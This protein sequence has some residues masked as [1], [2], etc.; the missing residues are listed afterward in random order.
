MDSV[1][2]PY[3]AS[4]MPRRLA[5][6]SDA[7]NG[8]CHRSE[9]LFLKLGKD[10]ETIYNGVVNITSQTQ[11][12]ARLIR[13]ESDESV[14]RKV[15]SIAKISVDELEVCHTEAEKNLNHVKA[16]SEQ[17]G[18]LCNLC[19]TAEKVAM[20]LK[21]V[22]V[23]MGI[24]CA[25]T[26]KSRETFSGFAVEV[27]NVSEKIRQIAENIRKK[28][29]HARED[30]L[31][32]YKEVSDAMEQLRSLSGST[33]VALE[34]AVVQIEEVM[35]FSSEILEQAEVNSREIS[36]MV[37]EIVM[38]I[39][40]HDSMNQRVSHIVHAI[41][42]THILWVEKDEKKS[43]KEGETERLSYSYAILS[44]QAAQLKR[45]ISEIHEVYDKNNLAFGQI[46]LKV[47]ELAQSLK[48]LD[49]QNLKNRD[50]KAGLNPHS[51]DQPK[52]AG[53]KDPMGTL[54]TAMGDL[55]TIL[56]QGKNLSSQIRET[57][58]EASEA[59]TKLSE[60]ADRVRNIG[61]ETRL[62]AINAIVNAT[63]LGESGRTFEVIA[64]E[65][66]NLAVQSNDFVVDVDQILDRITELN[67][68]LQL[69][70]SA[71]QRSCAVSETAISL[72]GNLKSI[73]SLYEHFIGSSTYI[74]EQS[75]VLEN[76]INQIR[77]SLDFL[78]LLAD[79]FTEYLHNFDRM[80]NALR[81][82]AFE[83][84]ALS[85]EEFEEIV[86]RY[87]ME[88]ER[89]IHQQFMDESENFLFSYRAPGN[90]G[91]DQEPSSS[92]ED[93]E[94]LGDNVELF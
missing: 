80:E 79:E 92:D 43:G 59:T 17:L 7:L 44:L 31:R 10:L 19:L 78:P 63:S 67:H 70:D 1:E 8:A 83:S 61:S 68:T 74:R 39:Q 34:N 20:Y 62:M 22:G 6:L 21:V 90:T 50:D 64:Q 88:Q 66:S 14:I 94:D 58:A 28:A 42:D 29:D 51:N 30:Q 57:I 46:A 35:K 75:G 76:Q 2:V 38:G 3:L 91:S 12:T 48:T 54:K 53:N 33:Q 36:Q 69:E 77:N 32:A 13:G 18:A 84:S 27:K 41:E 9:P 87:T 73:S 5:S 65:I 56:D 16:V 40:L 11:E 93:D 55:H 85:I 23:N 25:R 86:R 47:G 60:Q 82:A 45:I 15:G 71:Y 24:K 81:D 52:A 37:G 49:H 72:E 89:E 4:E 26:E